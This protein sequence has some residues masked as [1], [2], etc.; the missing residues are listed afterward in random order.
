MKKATG[1]FLILFMSIGALT[2]RDYNT[3]IGLR[4]GF[5][6][7]VSVKH[8]ISSYDALE[9]VIATHHSGLFLAGMY[10]RHAGAFD[11]PGLNWYYGGGAHLGFYN[12]KHSS[13]FKD[14][15]GSFTILGGMGV[16]GLEY[17]IEEI[18]ISIGLDL[19]PALNIIGHSGFWFGAGVTIRYV[20]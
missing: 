17:K 8:F 14:D 10:Q 4:G 12:A 20:F 11:V 2:A 6:S 1:I 15:T 9:G 7:G 3:G 18:P 19:T 16:V 5:Y 13:W